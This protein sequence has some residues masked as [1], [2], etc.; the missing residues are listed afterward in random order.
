MRQIYLQKQFY[1]LTKQLPIILIEQAK[2]R[3]R[4]IKVWETR[5]V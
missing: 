2:S 3:L 4:L 5:R 1:R